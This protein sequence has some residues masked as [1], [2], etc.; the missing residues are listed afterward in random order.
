MAS[1]LPYM[2]LWVDDALADLM[3]MGLTDE[4]FG[5]YWRLLLVAWKKDGIPADIKERARL[6][7]ASPRKL[8]ALW[9]AFA[10]KWESDG[11]GLLVNP[12]QQRE[13]SE[14]L[15][16]HAKRVEAGRKGGK[17]RVSKANA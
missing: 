15:E 2:R 4:E 11:N 8:E 13:K 5:A 1:E 16:A 3:E 10:H 7:H 17:Q 6:V 12:R 14:A 9:P